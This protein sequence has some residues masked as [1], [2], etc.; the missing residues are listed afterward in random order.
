MNTNK[1]GEVSMSLLRRLAK[2]LI[3][4]AL[5]ASG[6]FKCRKLFAPTALR[7]EAHLTE[8]CNLNCA[9]CNHF[10]PLAEKEFLSADGFERD[11][12]QLS[13]L[14]GGRQTFLREIILLGGEPL[15]HEEITRFFAI[16]RRYFST[17]PLKIFTNGILLE[18]Q[19][20]TFWLSCREHNVEIYISQYPI[21]IHFDKISQIAERYGVFCRFMGE[22]ITSFGIMPLDPNRGQNALRSFLNC[23]SSND[24]ATLRDGRMYQCCTAAHIKHLNNFFGENFAIGEQ[25]YIDIH[26]AKSAK[27]VLAFFTRPTPF[28]G[29]CAVGARKQTQW[30]SSKRDKAEW[31]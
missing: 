3:P 16:A 19:D 28:C 2:R 1:R 23:S 27:E 21:H 20:E 26:E 22:A 24:F 12:K 18:R 10:S 25:D 4:S 7:L 11:I 5:H 30:R 29:Y 31:I 8:H 17:I 6:I 14:A 13:F 9:S 15:L